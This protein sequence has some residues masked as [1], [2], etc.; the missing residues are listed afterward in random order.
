MKKFI[1]L[2]LALV[3]CMSLFAACG[4]K[5]EAG[6]KIA[7][8]KGT[9]SFMYADMIKNVTVVK[10]KLFEKYDDFNIFN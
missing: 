5:E 8:Q 10:M 3:L 2:A 6:A 9:T 4:S 7:A 1:A